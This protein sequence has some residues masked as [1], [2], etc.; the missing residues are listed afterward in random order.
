[1]NYETISH[2]EVTK[3]QIERHNREKPFAP[4]NGEELK[5]CIG[6]IVIFTNEFG[7]EFLCMITGYYQPD[8]IDAMYARGHRYLT[9]TDAYWFPDKES[10]L[11]LPSIKDIIRLSKS[12]HSFL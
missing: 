1:M 12:G 3:R 6:E 10:S 9:N 5:Y 4:E 7:C 11:R 8:P 2:H